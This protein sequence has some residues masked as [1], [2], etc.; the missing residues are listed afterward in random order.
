M[1]YV[2]IMVHIEEKYKARDGEVTKTAAIS[3][4]S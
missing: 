1:P 2:L 3:Y 4:E